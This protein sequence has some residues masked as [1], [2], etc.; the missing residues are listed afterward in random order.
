MTKREELLQIA[1]QLAAGYN[2]TGD[3]NYRDINIQSVHKR[4]T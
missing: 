4:W 3:S 1:T 2:A